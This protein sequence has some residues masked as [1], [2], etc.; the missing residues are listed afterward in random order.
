M[1]ARSPT[2]SLAS[3][4]PFCGGRYWIESQSLERLFGFGRVCGVGIVHL[5]HS[6]ANAYA[7]ACAEVGVLTAV[8]ISRSGNGAHV[9]T[10]L[11]RTGHGRDG[12][13]IRRRRA[14]HGDDRPRPDRPGQ[15]RPALSCPGRP[16]QPGQGSTAVRKPDRPS[17]AGHLPPRPHDESSATLRRGRSTPTSSSSSRVF[18][19]SAR[20]R[21]APSQTSSAPVHVGMTAPDHPRRLSAR[22]T[23]LSVRAPVVEARLNAML[24]IDTTGLPSDLISALKHTASLH[25]PEFIA[26]S[27]SA[28]RPSAYPGSS[29]ASKWTVRRCGCRAA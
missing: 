14:A 11:H 17:F 2:R 28:T 26:A 4:L 21:S 24:S 22:T 1:K 19:D 23:E 5:V 8:E 9:W 12:P 18:A 13:C 7:Q 6:D 27:S 10:V 29:G 3:D 15:L 20:A 16:A 25:N